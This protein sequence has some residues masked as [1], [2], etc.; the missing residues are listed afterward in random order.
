MQMA[1]VLQAEELNILDAV[2]IIKVTIGSLKK[3]NE[4]EAGINA[5]TQAGIHFARKQVGEPEAEFAK[6]H[7]IRRKPIRTDEHPETE[8]D[9]HIFSQGIQKCSRY[10]NQ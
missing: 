4:D 9:V 2:E 7:R 8:I 5:Q 10:A 3:I 1:A 6:K